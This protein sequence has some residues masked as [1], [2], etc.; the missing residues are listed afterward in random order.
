MP[1]AI[2]AERRVEIGCSMPLS[3]LFLQSTKTKTNLQDKS[4][5]IGE[6]VYVKQ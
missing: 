5:L 2:F 3:F 6:N 1:S 4:K